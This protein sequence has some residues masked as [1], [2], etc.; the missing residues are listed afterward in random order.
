MPDVTVL[1]DE[2]A[3]MIATSRRARSETSRLQDESRQLLLTYRR[4]RLCVA[5]GGDGRNDAG[6]AGV[7]MLRHILETAP[8]EALCAAC[9]AFA[10]DITLQR[11]QRLFEAFSNEFP[12]FSHDARMCASCRRHTLTIKYEGL[13]AGHGA[14]KHASSDTSGS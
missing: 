12:F 10:L 13:E 4:H 6:D 3:W 8:G 11:S 2:G 9:V 14:K 5:S 1:L 7:A